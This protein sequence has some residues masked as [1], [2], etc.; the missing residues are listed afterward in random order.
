MIASAAYLEAAGVRFV[1]GSVPR[2]QLSDPLQDVREQ[3][4]FRRL[5]QKAPLAFLHLTGQ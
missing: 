5:T 2:R 3:I 4:L 1:I